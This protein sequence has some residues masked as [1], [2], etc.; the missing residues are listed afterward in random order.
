MSSV[1]IE[2]LLYEEIGTEFSKLAEL[3]PGTERH[4]AA[5]DTLAKLMDR[6]IEIEKVESDCKEKEL[7]RESEKLLKE[8][9]LNDDKKDRLVKNIIGAAGV[10]LP[11]IVTIWGAKASMNFEKEGSFTTVMGRGFISKLLP[12]K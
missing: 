6:A 8:Q 5:A 11:L 2:H 1:N 3:E 9:Q 7:A 10:V 12:K 4:K